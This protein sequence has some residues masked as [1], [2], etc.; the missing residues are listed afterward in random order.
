MHITVRPQPDPRSLD[1]RR[2]ARQKVVGDPGCYRFRLAYLPPYGWNAVLNFLGAR[3]TPGVECVE[4]GRYRR[5]IQVDGENGV[6]DVSRLE[7]GA[8]LRLDVRVPDPRA[9][10]FVVERV[11]RVFDLGADP[12]AVGGHLRADPLLRRPLAKHPG[13]RTPGAW[14]GFELAVRAI[15]GQQI[16]VRAATTIAGRLASM[17]GSPVPTDRGLHRLFPAPAQLAHASIERAGVMPARAETIRLLARHVAKGTIS[18]GSGVDAAAVDAAA[19]VSALQDLPGIGRWTAEY[20]AMR[21]FGEPDAF[22]SG[23][24]VLRRA[25]GGCTARELD[26]KSQAW[27]PWRAYAVMLLWQGATDDLVRAARG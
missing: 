24:L 14:D 17:F 9:L 12:R 3:A 20:I 26:R 5:T 22:P 2:L 7:S 27:R 15:L 16:S 23:D 18:F 10:S 21:A 19:T 4:A 8:A 13:I 11:R 6:I 25:A 1:L